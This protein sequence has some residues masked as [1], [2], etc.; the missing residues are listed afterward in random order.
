MG[1]GNDYPLTDEEYE[2]LLESQYSMDS[3]GSGDLFQM[4]KAAFPNYLTD[5]NRNI[6]VLY[7]TF[8]LVS[9]RRYKKLGKHPE[10]EATANRLGFGM[11]LRHAL[12]V[13]SID[14]TIKNGIDANGKT[15]HERLCAL[16]GQNIPDYS[17]EKERV[18]FTM[19][20][21]TND[22]AHPR[23]NADLLSY[24][25]LKELYQNS[26]QPV[27]E[28][29]LE[30]KCKR[31][32]KKY[33]T[34]INEQLRGFKVSNGIT[35]TLILGCLIRQL[36]EC[37]V[38]LWCFNNSM[39]PTDASTAEYPI[40]MGRL[41]A[42]L[43]HIAR[44]QSNYGFGI[45]AMTTEVIDAL[46]E[47]KNASNGLMHVAPDKVTLRSIKQHHRALVPLYGK[48]TV[49]CSPSSLEAKLDTGVGKRRALFTMLLC[50][51]FGW[52]GAHHFY[53]GNTVKGI[54]FLLTLGCGIGPMGSL[55]Y[56]WDGSF[57]SKKWGKLPK[58]KLISFFS[59]VFVIL[60]IV[61]LIMLYKALK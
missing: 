30:Q 22:I 45:S 54:F 6:Q 49:E 59:S 51:F 32:V 10:L 47:L 34:T 44:S 42:T 53:A 43:D 38:N 13:I 8:H 61:A 36:T 55:I 17:K 16:Q 3:Y 24:E 21:V 12:E 18:L 26:F 25:E 58:T 20:N 40:K 15:V 57:E 28:A 4:F 37:T 60:H 33:L 2:L 19:L 39:L 41:L 29:H 5:L 11:L 46:F 9:R 48:V 27:I 31:N 56:L 7:D 14:V 1:Y 52:T 50:G 35:R 23:V